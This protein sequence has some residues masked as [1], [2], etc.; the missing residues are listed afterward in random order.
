LSC[1]TPLLLLT[2]SKASAAARTP[3]EQRVPTW[4]LFVDCLLHDCPHKSTALLGGGVRWFA[5]GQRSSTPK[6]VSPDEPLLAAP[7]LAC[8]SGLAAWC[9]LP[10]S[11]S[12]AT[13]VVYP[14]REAGGP[15]QERWLCTRACR[16]ML[17][18]CLQSDG[19][20]FCEA[21]VK[22][23]AQQGTDHQEPRLD[24]CQTGSGLS[25]N[26][27]LD[28]ALSVT[29]SPARRAHLPLQPSVENSSCGTSRRVVEVSDYQAAWRLPLLA[30]LRPLTVRVTFCVTTGG[31]K[32]RRF[33]SPSQYVGFLGTPSVSLSPS[34]FPS[35][36]SL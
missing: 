16:P 2:E 5:A 28:L 10:V 9:D 8:L 30:T 3:C 6:C 11:F 24:T 17:A 23:P 35:T 27:L 21:S 26:S 20:C 1:T 31:R 33:C 25:P 13:L 12:H 34:C 7:A 32:E 29:N 14:A 36:V 22:A 19:S 18:F 4:T 15:K